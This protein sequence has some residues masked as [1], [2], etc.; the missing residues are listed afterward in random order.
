[1][2]TPSTPTPKFPSEID[3]LRAA[4]QRASTPARFVEVARVYVSALEAE[5]ARMAAK[6]GAA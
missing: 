4:Y 6:E 2:T 1:M 5:V 3:H